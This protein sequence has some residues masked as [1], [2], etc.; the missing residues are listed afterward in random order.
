M[1][2]KT[3]APDLS[4]FRVSCKA[5]DVATL[6]IIAAPI[7]LSLRRQSVLPVRMRPSSG[8][9]LAFFRGRKGTEVWHFKSL[10]S[11][12]TGKKPC[13]LPIFGPHQKMLRRLVLLLNVILNIRVPA[14]QARVRGNSFVEGARQRAGI[15]EKKFVTGYRLSYRPLKLNSG[16][17]MYA[18][19]KLTACEPQISLTV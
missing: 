15:Q 8:R 18:V 9:A 5:G 17:I 3:P 10:R 11:T 19:S 7:R 16:I 4:K 14:V 6:T 2:N 12:P 13:K 1:Q